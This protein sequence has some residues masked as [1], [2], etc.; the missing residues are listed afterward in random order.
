MDFEL[1]DEQRMWQ[2]AVHNFVAAEV[3]PRAREVDETGEFNWD[4]SAK[5][6][7]VRAAGVECPGGIRRSRGGCGQRSHR[8]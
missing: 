5:N 1:N 8:D 7:P 6:G 4:G 3:K 2:A